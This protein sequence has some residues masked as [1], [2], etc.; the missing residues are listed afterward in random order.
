MTLSLSALTEHSAGQRQIAT[1]PLPT[2]LLAQASYSR[3]EV[4][5]ALGVA[6]IQPVPSTASHPLVGEHRRLDIGEPGAP[7]TPEQACIVNGGLEAALGHENEVVA[8]RA[9]RR[10]A[11]RLP[12]TDKGVDS[13][14]LDFRTDGYGGT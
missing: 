6:S 12:R 11:H 9:H 3:E 2:C 7:V 8:Q 10:R 5:A 4:P 13:E 1:T 14:V